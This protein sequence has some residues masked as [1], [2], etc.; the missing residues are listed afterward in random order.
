M[1]DPPPPDDRVL[2]DSERT[3]LAWKA[4]VSAAAGAAVVAFMSFM[5]WFA[6]DAPIGAVSPRMAAL[7]VAVAA[8]MVAAAV[9]SRV[10]RRVEFSPDGERLVLHRDPG[11][12]ESFPVGDLVGARSDAPSGG[13][14]RDPSD[15]LVLALRDG[16]E[17]RYALPDDADTPGIVRDITARL[18]ATPGRS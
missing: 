16:S 5:R 7:G 17:R 10:V 12:L 11:A 14:S 1:P 13:W 2:Y 15:V 8:A 3:S 9:R 6:R 4:L 18:G